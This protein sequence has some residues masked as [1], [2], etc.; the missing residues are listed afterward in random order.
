VICHLRDRGISQGTGLGT[1]LIKA[2]K[3]QVR[4]CIISP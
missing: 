2:F 4:R 1:K 3:D